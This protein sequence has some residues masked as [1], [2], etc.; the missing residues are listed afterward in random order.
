MDTRLAELSR[1]IDPAELGRRIRVARVA[2]GMTQVQVAGEDITAA[3]LSRIEDG[4][5]RPEAL[6]LG[7]LAVRMGT[8][9]E[10]LLI[11]VS[12]DERAELQLGLD[13]AELALAGGDAPQALTRAEQLL[14][15]LER[16]ADTELV[17]RARRIRASALEMT[18]DL[19]G[20]IMAFED[21]VGEPIA[22]AVWLKDLISL[23]RCYRDGG[24]PAR[25]IEV[26]DRARALIV[27]LGLE[28]LTEA[29]Q[30]SVTVAAAYHVRGDLGEAM[31]VCKRA[32]AEAEKYDSPIGKASAYWNASLIDAATHGATPQSLD[33]ARKALALFELGDDNRNL[34]KLRGLVARLH[35]STTPPEPQA[36]LDI[37]AVAEREL[38]VGGSAW[39]QALV[40]VNRGRA[41]VLLGRLD[42]AVASAERALAES[43]AKASLLDAWAHVVLG[44]AAALDA[45][46]SDAREHYGRAIHALTAA[47]ADR[48]AAQLWFDLG[49]LLTDVGDT[50]GALQA[51]RNA[52]ASTGLRV[53]ESPT[54]HLRA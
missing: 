33:L 43:P 44:Q 54:A 37:M 45:R 46:P 50:D 40:H 2:A 9:L 35:L 29:I 8:T 49:T 38:A 48:E 34:A 31:R 21:L 25:A 3:Y 41:L 24:E 28:G 30:L 5:R 16:T 47:G 26:G 39:D 20:A 11:G 12:H 51:F 19:D 52:G 17:R 7:R 1:T 42:E 13:H 53:G 22:D 27:E 6:L 14:A 10:E 4:Q 32:L 15:R 36:A 18:G 23:S